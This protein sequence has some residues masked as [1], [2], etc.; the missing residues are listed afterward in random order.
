MSLIKE[1]KRENSKLKEEV[2]YL[3]YQ[4]RML[5]RMREELKAEIGLKDKAERTFSNILAYLMDTQNI[6][7]F[8]M[9][10]KICDKYERSIMAREDF[11]N[12][13]LEFIVVDAAEE[14]E[15]ADEAVTGRLDT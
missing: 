8:R 10:N 1:L 15:V 11:I 6:D 14:K 7:H 12:S 4:K 2:R 5:L 13:E 9:P 3:E